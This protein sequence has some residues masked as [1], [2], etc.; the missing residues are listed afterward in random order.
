MREWFE[1]A[2]GRVAHVHLQARG[3]DGL[4]TTIRDRPREVVEAFARLQALGFAG[5]ATVEFTSGVAAPGEDPAQVFDC[6]CA[7]LQFLRSE[8]GL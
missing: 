7:D 8:A 1:A 5:S 6:A 2:Q 3:A 4:F